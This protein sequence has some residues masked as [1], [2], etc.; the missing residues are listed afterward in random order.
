M[1]V[2][3]DKLIDHISRSTDFRQSSN[4]IRRDRTKDQIEKMTSDNVRMSLAN[5]SKELKLSYSMI[6]KKNDTVELIVKSA[7]RKAGHSLQNVVLIV[8][9]ANR[10]ADHSLQKVELIIKSANHKADHIVCR[11]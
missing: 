4:E 1:I 8:K 6:V 10:K 7:N 5:R 9:Y 11:T 3:Q 2:K